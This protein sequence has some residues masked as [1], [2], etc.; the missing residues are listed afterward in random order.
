MIR[1]R[2]SALL[3]IIESVLAGYGNRPR[4]GLDATPPTIGARTERP[5]AK[6]KRPPWARRRG[7]ERRLAGRSEDD[8]R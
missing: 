6:P 7:G 8:E 5:W 4:S 3:N 1:P 2:A